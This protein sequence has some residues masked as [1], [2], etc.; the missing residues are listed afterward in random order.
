VA[1]QEDEG[2][3]AVQRP[4]R[5][6]G[7]GVDLDVVGPKGETGQPVDGLEGRAALHRHHLVKGGP[8]GP[9]ELVE[10]TPELDGEGRQGALEAPPAGDLGDDAVGIAIGAAGGARSGRVIIHDGPI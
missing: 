3:A 6:E 9:V 5:I 7:L 1:R 8:A 10:R 2:V 4:Q